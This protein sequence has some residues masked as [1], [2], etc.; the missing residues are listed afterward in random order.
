MI[1]MRRTILLIL[2][3]LV[4]GCGVSNVISRGEYIDDQS[5]QI[6]DRRAVIIARFGSPIDKKVEG[7]NITEIYRV[8]Q[9]ETTTGKVIKAGGILLIDVFTFGLAEIVATPATR[10]TEKI[11]FEVYYDS[12][13]RVTGWKIISRQ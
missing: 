7:N 13:E 3:V 11:T 4:S 12:A 10:Q 1:S 9:G 8:P 6:G 2:I 5:I